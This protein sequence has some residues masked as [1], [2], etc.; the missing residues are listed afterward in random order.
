[1]ASKEN[2]GLQIAL[3]LF[4]MITVALGV[5]TYVFYTQVN[6]YSEESQK[7][8]AEKTKFQKLAEVRDIEVMLLKRTIGYG[9]LTDEELASQRSRLKG[10]DA[11]I[12]DEVAKIEADFDQDMKMFDAAYPNAKNWRT[13]PAYI[14]S[15]VKDRNI[16][17]TDGLGR[18]Q[19]LTVEKTTA[20]AAQTN[21]ADS[22]AAAQKKAEADLTDEASKFATSRTD[23][24]GYTATLEKEK[25]DALTAKNDLAKEKQ[26]EVTDLQ[27]EKAQLARTMEGYIAQ[28]KTLSQTDTFDLPDGHIRWVNQRTR[29]VWID[30]GIADGLRRQTTFSIYDQ[31]ASNFG[32]ATKKASVEV[33]KLI[34]PHLAEARILED[35]LSNPILPGDLLYTPAWVPGRRIKFAI[36]GFIDYNGDG[37]SDRELVKN[38]IAASGAD[39]AAEVTD[40]GEL[41]GEVTAEVK[42]LIVGDRP[43]ERS[44]PE[45]VKNF[46][47]ITAKAKEQGV[48]EITVQKF[49]DFMGFRPE[50]KTVP[51]GKGTGTEAN[52]GPF[53]PRQPP[54]RGEGGAF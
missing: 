52:Q 25:S 37:K 43:T 34:E 35:D 11:A 19:R 47:K 1:M 9:T 22:A 7:A 18:E 6:K 26:K 45:L 40:N 44:A 41:S 2:Q 10:Q 21:R 23:Y 12:S 15:V 53:R 14:E 48:E 27:A 49:L 17:V 54:A 5:T 38:L 32:K 28:I 29:V 13:L 4:V 30:L 39:V 36:A 16:A 50:V 46:G 42:Y 8:E 33:T 20:I 51:L 24:K 31:D 3:I